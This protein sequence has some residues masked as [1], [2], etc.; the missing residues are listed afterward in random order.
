MGSNDIYIYIHIY[1]IVTSRCSGA[2]GNSIVVDD[3]I[4]VVIVESLR[5]NPYLICSPHFSRTRTTTRT[6]RRRRRKTKRNGNLEL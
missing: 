3:S 6:S 4:V 1:S 2:N 5:H